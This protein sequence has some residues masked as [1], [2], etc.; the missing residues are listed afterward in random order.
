MTGTRPWADL[1]A[2]GMTCLSPGAALY[3]RVM[4]HLAENAKE[5]RV[6]DLVTASGEAPSRSSGPSFGELHQ[7]MSK[8]RRLSA[9][10]SLSSPPSNALSIHTANLPSAARATSL[11][12]SVDSASGSC[13]DR[14][15]QEAG[16]ATVSL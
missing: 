14:N 13:S 15:L 5:L 2:T 11:L 9:A 8:A 10:C 3:L 12:G 1:R 16:L 4:G 6:G 7:V